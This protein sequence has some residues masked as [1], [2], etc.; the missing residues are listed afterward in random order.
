MCGFAYDLVDLAPC[1]HLLLSSIVRT[2]SISGFAYALVDLEC[3]FQY[4]H[5]LLISVMRSTSSY[6]FDFA[7][8]DLCVSVVCITPALIPICL[9]FYLPT[10]KG[11][12]KTKQ[13][14]TA[15]LS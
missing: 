13:C 12:K 9:K 4:F 8:V 6:G 7:L 2:T 11:M 1:F 5:L 15:M 10:R 14:R 3:V